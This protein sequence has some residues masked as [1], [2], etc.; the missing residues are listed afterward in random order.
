MSG[1]LIMMGFSQDATI[2]DEDN[3]VC[4]YASEISHL[5]RGMRHLDLA[6][7]LKKKKRGAGRVTVRRPYRCRFQFYDY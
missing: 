2:I 6:E 4:V 5:T 7:M 1:T 3:Q